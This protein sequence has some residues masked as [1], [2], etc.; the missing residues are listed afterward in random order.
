MSKYTLL[1]SFLLLNVMWFG[2]LSQAN[3]RE[4]EGLPHSGLYP[5][6]DLL[7]AVAS[8]TERSCKLNQR[9]QWRSYHPKGARISS[10]SLN[11]ILFMSSICI[12]MN[13]NNECLWN[14]HSCWTDLSLRPRLAMSPLCAY[15]RQV[16][17]PSWFLHLSERDAILLVLEL[18]TLIIVYVKYPEGHSTY[19]CFVTKSC[20]TLLLPHG[21]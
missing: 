13:N 10:Y 15:L 7:I 20:P 14:S 6:Q 4:L 1:C 11:A 8:P 12:V 18:F 19:C 3:G 5:H 16:M 21:L 2:W 17:W 9:L